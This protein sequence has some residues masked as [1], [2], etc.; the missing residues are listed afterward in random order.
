MIRS[1]LIG[2]LCLAGGLAIGYFAAYGQIDESRH[3]LANLNEADAARPE[4]T[5]PFSV[6]QVRP[7]SVASHAAEDEIPA[8]A[9]V[10]PR[11]NGVIT[12]RVLDV[13]GK[14]VSG[15]RLKARREGR[16]E[17]RN[18]DRPGMVRDEMLAP[19]EKMQKHQAALLRDPSMESLALSDAKGEFRLEGLDREPYSISAQ[20]AG[21]ELTPLDDPSALS[22]RWPGDSVALRAVRLGGVVVQVVG[23]DG[24]APLV[25]ELICTRNDATLNFQWTA[26]ENYFPLAEGHWQLSAR[27]GEVGELRSEKALT[28]VGT[29]GTSA[30]VELKLEERPHVRGKLVFEGPVPEHSLNVL[31]W[32]EKQD[33]ATENRWNANTVQELARSLATQGFLFNDL[34]PGIYRLAVGAGDMDED[35][36]PPVLATVTV[37]ERGVVQDLAVRDMASGPEWAI[38]V[39]NPDGLPVV[40]A[41]I[42]TTF[43]MGNNVGWRRGADGIQR[44]RVPKHIRDGNADE[45]LYAWI[46]TGAF[47][48]A[49]LE[50][51]RTGGQSEVR[52]QA[53]G[54]LKVRFLSTSDSQRKTLSASLQFNPLPGQQ[55]W[56]GNQEA[57]Q[58]GEATFA[59]LQP[60]SYTLHLNVPTGGWNGSQNVSSQTVQIHSGETT[61]DLGLP[62]LFGFNVHVQSA[63]TGRRNGHVSLNAD[64]PGPEGVNYNTNAR[65]SAEGHAKFENVPAGKYRLQI[66]DSGRTLNK[67]ITVPTNG[68]VIL[69]SEKFRALQLN[70][71]DQNAE[72]AKHGLMSGDLIIGA[73]GQ[74]FE[75]STALATAM[76]FMTGNAEIKLMVLRAGKTE[77]LSLPA[78]VLSDHQGFNY[79]YVQR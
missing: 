41:T 32:N 42:E 61:V 29:S 22:S 15:V 48:K 38:A 3:I 64:N 52:L 31:L 79:S 39:L 69:D 33:P 26:A 8:A 2:L 45:R 18:L 25:A 6:S 65:L 62:M 51:A 60:G 7:L 12:G 57:G 16:F 44:G 13:D 46:S 63:T 34:E 47:G 43:W 21:F 72:I 27:G 40:D 67:H 71:H 70:V 59:P 20:L 37:A 14:P 76:R 30:T 50:L 49:A 23:P 66:W 36:H 35:E 10:L 54:S 28:V 68:D 77:T 11:G 5:N 55:L 4:S 9:S 1:L 24:K 75:S 56:V 74:E 73:N 58:K 19:E 53:P 78:N 17:P